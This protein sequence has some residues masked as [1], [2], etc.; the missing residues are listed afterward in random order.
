[1]YGQAKDKAAICRAIC[2]DSG[3]KLTTA[4]LLEMFI[5]KNCHFYMTVIH[6]KKFSATWGC[7]EHTNILWE[8]IKTS[9]LAIISGNCAQI[10]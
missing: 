6:F 7:Y 10:L 8:M 4:P 5:F 9:G 2:F 3:T 1:M